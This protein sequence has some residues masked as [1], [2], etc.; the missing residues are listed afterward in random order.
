MRSM[1]GVHNAAETH[2]WA[3]R[4]RAPLVDSFVVDG[5]VSFGPEGEAEALGAGTRLRL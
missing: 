3:P 5:D 2:L 1:F 4:P